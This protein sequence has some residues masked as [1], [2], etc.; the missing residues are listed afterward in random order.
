MN[1]TMSLDSFHLF[2]LLPTEIH[3]HIWTL[4]LP[5]PRRIEPWTYVQIEPGSFDSRLTRSRRRAV[6]W[7]GPG[8]SCA[9]T[10]PAALRVNRESRHETLQHYTPRDYKHLE[11]LV[12]R[13]NVRYEA[14][15][16]FSRETVAFGVRPVDGFGHDY[17]RFLLE[18]EKQKVLH[19]ELAS[20]ISGGEHLSESLA[21]HIRCFPNVEDIVFHL[22]CRS[23]EGDEW[24]IWHDGPEFVE[25]GSVSASIREARE[26]AEDI[27]E[28][29][30]ARQREAGAVWKAPLL[31]LRPCLEFE[32]PRCSVEEVRR[33]VEEARTAAK[34]GTPSAASEPISER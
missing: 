10:D 22:R 11:K 1:N 19:L 21:E 32:K 9:K 28:A 4:A 24:S 23:I 8:F 18:N 20:W 15:I 25:T 29:Y 27:F 34:E 6:E 31:V 3:L 16:D 13:D 26:F 7:R 33:L 17:D 12:E 5:E 2:P 14:F 30:E